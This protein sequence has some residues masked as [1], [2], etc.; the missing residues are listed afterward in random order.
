LRARLEA[1]VATMLGISAALTLCSPRWIEIL[2]G[3]EPDA[4]SGETELGVVAAIAA[5][6]LAVGLP[7]RRD[8]RLM[9]ASRP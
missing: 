3:L 4:G 2:T 5:L 8:Y 9:R 6:A 7:T 1:I